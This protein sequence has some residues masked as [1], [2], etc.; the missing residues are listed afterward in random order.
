[1]TDKNSWGTMDE[2]FRIVGGVLCLIIKDYKVLML[3]RK[4][5]FD[6]GKY[7]VPG[8]CMEDGETVTMAAMR[9]VKEEVGL[10]IKE[11][12]IEV[13][14]TFHRMC[15]WGWQSVEFVAV[16]TEFSGEPKVMEPEKSDKVEWFSMDNLPENI[17]LY[18]KKAIENY[19]N[20]ESFSE[21]D[22]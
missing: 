1:M 18:A 9:E 19:I 16:V 15:P 22:Y 7:S 20:E 10:D 8:G 2:R 5:K 13:V 17:S 4:G 21:I 3:L 11:E 12:D 6:A 14:T